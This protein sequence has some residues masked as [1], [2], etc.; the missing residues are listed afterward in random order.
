VHGVASAAR[1]APT[2][3]SQ[4]NQTNHVPPSVT[5]LLAATAT[6]YG[7]LSASSSLLQAR[8]MTRRHRSQDVSLAFLASITGSYL[9][10]LL[11][12]ICIHN[13]PLIAVDSTGLASGAFTCSIAARLRRRPHRPAN[14]SRHLIE[15]NRSR[16][17]VPRAENSTG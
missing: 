13:V 14:T 5:D 6:I 4:L 15:T 2:N 7:L 11:Y 17:R 10:W 12:G 9:I 8:R 16:T 3:E 1:A